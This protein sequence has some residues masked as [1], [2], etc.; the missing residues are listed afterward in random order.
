M[1]PGAQLQA[2]GRGGPSGLQAAFGAS[3]AGAPGDRTAEG[4]REP[5]RVRARGAGAPPPPV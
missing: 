1:F 4:A 2:A 5:S 3:E